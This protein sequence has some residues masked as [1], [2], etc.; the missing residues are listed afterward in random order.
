MSHRYSRREVMQIASGILGTR[1]MQIGPMFPGPGMPRVTSVPSATFVQST[2]ATV[3][4]IKT[5]S[6]AFNSNNTAGNTLVVIASYQNSVAGVGAASI[7]DTRG[8]TYTAVQNLGDGI[9]HFLSNAWIVKNCAA[10]ANTVTY[11]NATISIGSNALS[12]ALVEYS[13]LGTN[14]TVVS[15]NQ[16]YSSASAP[17]S[18]SCTNNAGTT[19]TVTDPSSG[20]SNNT[21]FGIFDLFG[22]ATELLVFYESDVATATRVPTLAPSGSLTMRENALISTANTRYWDF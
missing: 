5:I 20:I 21:V 1:L 13:G 9:S 3:G 10:G 22:N 18:V 16:V 11:D 14:P 4:G 2:S 6:K 7:S 17:A 19:L 12:I 8:N 15:K